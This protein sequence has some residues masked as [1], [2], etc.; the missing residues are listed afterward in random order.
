MPLD[1]KRDDKAIGC[2]LIGIVSLLAFGSAVEFL[3]MA[4]VRR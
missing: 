1:C 3:L 2:V 4:I